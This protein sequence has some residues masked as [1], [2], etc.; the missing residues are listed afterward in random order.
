MK[1]SLLNILEHI[2]A[3]PTLPTDPFY[4]RQIKD[5]ISEAKTP[6][7]LPKPTPAVKRLDCSA[8][9]TCRK[10]GGLF[11]G[12]RLSFP[13]SVVF[14]DGQTRLTSTLSIGLLVATVRLEYRSKVTNHVT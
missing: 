12:F 3:N 14:C 11:L 1:S 8:S 5:A 9:W 13:S 2:A 10:V 6:L 4:L 7:Q